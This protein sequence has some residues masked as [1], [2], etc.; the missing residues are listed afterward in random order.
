MQNQI[1]RC[2]AV[3]GLV[4]KMEWWAVPQKVEFILEVV[5][6]K[7]WIWQKISICFLSQIYKWFHT[8]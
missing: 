3:L 4:W 8:N 5:D 1:G 2:R 7:M 6:I